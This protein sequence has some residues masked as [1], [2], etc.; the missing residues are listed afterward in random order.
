MSTVRR[1]RARRRRRRRWRKRWARLDR[2]QAAA[3]ALAA[4]QRAIDACPVPWLHVATPP[5]QRCNQCGE[6][7]APEA[8]QVLRTS[9]RGDDFQIGGR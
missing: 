4:D 3:R 9:A 7:V 8:A 6:R 1:R 5:G 2:L